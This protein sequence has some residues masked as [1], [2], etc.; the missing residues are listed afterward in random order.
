V[1][2]DNGSEVGYNI[3]GDVTGVTKISGVYFGFG[4]GIFDWL[5]T[6]DQLRYGKNLPH[7]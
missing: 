3:A 1:T 5:F 6:R 7:E 2:G 4:A